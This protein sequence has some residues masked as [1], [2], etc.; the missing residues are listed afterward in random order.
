MQLFQQGI[1]LCTDICFSVYTVNLIIII[2]LHK[3][4]KS[5]SVDTVWGKCRAVNESLRELYH[6]VKKRSLQ[7]RF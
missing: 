4:W 7:L 1:F 5:L 3:H 6:L 2:V